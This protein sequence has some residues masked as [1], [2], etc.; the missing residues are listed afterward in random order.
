MEYRELRSSEIALLRGTS[1][2]EPLPFE[3]TTSAGFVRALTGSRNSLSQTARLPGSSTITLQWAEFLRQ[4]SFASP[5]CEFRVEIWEKSRNRQSIVYS[6]KRFEGTPGFW[7]RRAVDLSA[8]GGQEVTITFVLDASTYSGSRITFALDDVRLASWPE[9]AGSF[10]V[11]LGTNTVLDDTTLL[12]RTSGLTWPV[13]RLSRNRTYYWRVA[14]GSDTNLALGPTW[15][16]S[17]RREA[18]TLDHFDM[19][20]VSASTVAGEPLPATFT[21]MDEDGRA[22]AVPVSGTSAALCALGGSQ[23]SSVV[24][25]EVDPRATNAVEFM[26]VSSQPVVLSGWQAYF[27]ASSPATL[28]GFFRFPDGLHASL[29]RFLRCAL[30]PAQGDIRTSER[31]PAARVSGGIA[32]PAHPGPGWC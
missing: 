26:N 28:S 11:Y 23:D 2:G 6:T 31:R 7:S 24:I 30:V 1:S 3:G 20:S 15:S 21:A 32:A 12:G 18:T 22:L 27:Y 19:T 9:Q 29:G 4:D 8:F 16:F 5:G 25:T 17:T 14:Y 10:L 13:A